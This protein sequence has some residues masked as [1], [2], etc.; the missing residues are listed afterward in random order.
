MLVTV[1]ITTYNRRKLLE[2]AINSVLNQT[3]SPIEL[4]VADDGSTD[5][6][7]EYLTEMHEQGI[8][9]AILNT[10]GKSKGACYGRNR[11]ISMAKGEF[12]SG[13][14]DDDYFEPWRIETFI[15]KWQ[16]YTVNIN[17]FSALFDSVV[18]HRKSG[19]VACYDTGVATYQKLR[20]GNVVGNQV[21]TK[22]SYLKAV[23]GFDEQMPALQDWD[24]WLRL[25][26]QYGDILN[27]NTR[28]YIQIQNHEGE[29]ITGKPADK[30]RFAFNRL[31][32]KLQPLTR[33]EESHLLATMYSGYPQIDIRISELFKI[34][35]GGHFRKVAQVVKRTLLK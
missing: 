17:V 18:E 7:Q 5:G 11:A 3:H 34:F 6:S 35:M 23:G 10:T 12:I 27:V 14:D 2:R 19:P 28:S 21:F 32:N 24:T 16:E 31:M 8:L 33:S 26:N 29:R 9:T 25:S 4:I 13:L 20:K 22:T 30:I 1:Y 15:K